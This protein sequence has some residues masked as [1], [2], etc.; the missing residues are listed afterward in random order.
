METEKIIENLFLV[1]SDIE[2]REKG[3]NCLS[4]LSWTQLCDMGIDLFAQLK[5]GG[6]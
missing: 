3:N 5:E 4:V 1:V 6:I 2:A